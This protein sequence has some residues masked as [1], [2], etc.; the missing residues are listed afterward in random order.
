MR[1]VAFSSIFHE[2]T[3]SN[4]VLFSTVEVLYI[5]QDFLFR[6]CNISEA[7]FSVMWY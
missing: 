3:R 2:Q 5:S 7:W 1:N 4:R 6:L